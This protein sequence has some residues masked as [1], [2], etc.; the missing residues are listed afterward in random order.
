MICLLI[1]SLLY[2]WRYKDELLH[3]D[4]ILL[5]HNILCLTQYHT[6]QTETNTTLKYASCL[7]HIQ[8]KDNKFIHPPLQITNLKLSIQECNLVKDI[9]TNQPTIQIQ[10]SEANIYDQ[11]G[12][13]MATITRERLQWLWNQFCYHR[14]TRSTISLQPPPQNFGT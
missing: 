6:K 8:S 14:P 10:D 9:Q 7:N 4:N 12:N 2:W 3:P 5:E 1:Y 13:Y 11:Q